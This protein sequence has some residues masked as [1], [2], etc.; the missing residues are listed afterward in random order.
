[1]ADRRTHDLKAGVIY[2]MARHKLVLIGAGS[3]VF[4]QRLVSDLILSGDPSK[5]ELA[6]VDIDEEVLDLV[7]KLVGKMLDARGADIHVTATTDRCEALPGAN[8]VVTTIAVGGRRGWELDVTIPRKY[9]IYQPVGDTVMPGGISRAMRMIPQMIDIAKDVA[10]LCPDAHFF[11]YSNPMTA[12]CRAVRKETGVPLVG[13]CHGLH[14]V[15]GHLARFLEVEEGTIT[16]FGVGLNHLTFLLDIFYE[17]RDAYPMI[18]EKLAEQRETL[19]REIE[20][21][22]EWPNLVTGRPPRY[23]DDPFT[24]TFVE[25]YGVFP[26]MM[27]RHASEFFPERFPN[28]RYYGGTRLGID[29]FPIDRRIAQG[30]EIYDDMARMAR[31]EDPLPKDFFEH[32]PGEHEQLLEIL[33]SLE[34][35]GRETFSV[36]L[37]NEGAVPNLPHNA[38]LELPGTATSRGFSQLHS[39]PMPD[40]LAAILLRK[41]T[42]IEITVEAA[43]QGSREL[44]VEALI[45]DG[46]IT[47]VDTARKLSGELIEAHREHLPQFAA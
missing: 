16:T 26:V 41:I 33:E 38:I 39:G 13:L 20:A 29:A 6:L 34:T 30:D 12:V 24:W 22:D 31:S 1:M 35:D 17:G 46:A 11:N 27:D 4:T 15:E 9:D 45:A 5:W 10:E 2:A 44:F 32:V 42:S 37:P 19:W 43:L 36:N 18:H 40:V 47:D 28:G 8:S 25:R 23:S 7:H 3:T 14:H 21:K